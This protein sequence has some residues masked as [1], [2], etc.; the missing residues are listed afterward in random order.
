MERPSE[1]LEHRTVRLVRWRTGDAEWAFDLVTQALDHLRPYMP[2]ADGY[3]AEQN[4]A[5]LRSCE[6]DWDAGTSFQYSVHHQGHPVGSCGLLRR[7]ETE[8]GVMEIGYWL[9]PDHTGKGLAT[10][11][12]RLLVTAAF[13]LSDVGAVE[14]V[15]DEGNHASGA[16]PRRLNFT[17][18]GTR[19]SLP[20]L[21][22]ADSGTEVIW[23][24]TR[25]Q[26]AG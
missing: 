12:A 24:L 6:Q 11:S 22:P 26:A 5:F 25:Q 9:H 19:R 20:P 16:V 15:H 21:P 1:A 14:I 3:S 4:L 17:R 18:I 7:P 10:D 8:T 13:A 2:W 23:S